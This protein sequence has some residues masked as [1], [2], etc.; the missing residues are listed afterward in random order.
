M[1]TARR[2]R[3]D[4]IGVLIIVLV[5]TWLALGHDGRASESVRVRLLPFVEYGPALRCVVEHCRSTFRA[6]WFLLI[7]G[8]GNIVVF[9]PL[10]A[11]TC[12][13]LLRGS[14][15]RQRSVLVA[16][17]VGLS[18]SAAYEVAQLWIPGRVTATDDVL[19]NGAGT[20]LGAL[21]AGSWLSRHAAQQRA[22]H[23]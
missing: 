10:G 14:Q 9:M 2:L 21:V 20:L 12:A 4:W 6:G 15:R 22:D 5:L 18:L 1:N 16:T 8:L 13:V 11:A 23:L 17:L 7:N 19:L 3:A